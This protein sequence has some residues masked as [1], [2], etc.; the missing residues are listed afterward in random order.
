V[1]I[2]VYSKD[3]PIQILY[4]NENLRFL[5]PL[6]F[7]GRYI[8]L[9]RNAGYRPISTL[10]LLYPRRLFRAVKKKKKRKTTIEFC[11]FT[12]ITEDL[13]RYHEAL[14]A[15][16][17]NQ[18]EMELPDPNNPLSNLPFLCGYWDHT[19]TEFELPEAI[20]NNGQRCLWLYDEHRFSAWN[21]RLS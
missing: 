5:S 15:V 9:V 13:P 16:G 20:R 10:S 11:G 14:R 6:S 19:N 4:E 18:L 21:F 17:S 8:L 7:R 2:E 3:Q 12:N 1:C